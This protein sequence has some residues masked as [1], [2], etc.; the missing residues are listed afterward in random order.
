MHTSAFTHQVQLCL[1]Q[2]LHHL[3][4]AVLQLHWYFLH[5]NQWRQLLQHRIHAEQQCVFR[6]QVRLLIL[7]L[8]FL[9]AQFCRNLEISDGKDY[10]RM[11]K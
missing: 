1:I 2:E 3:P 7:I 4:K 11:K 6:K 8:F 5:G 9:R 10:W